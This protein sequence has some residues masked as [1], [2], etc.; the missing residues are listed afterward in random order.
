[1]SDM[2][3]EIDFS[4][5]HPIKDS[6]AMVL[7]KIEKSYGKD[8]ENPERYVQTGIDGL[9]LP[10]GGLVV[11]AAR[12]CYG[13]MACALSLARKLAVEDKKPVGI[14]ACGYNDSASVCTNLL[15]MESDVPLVR[16]RSGLLTVSDF[17]K[18]QAAAGRLYESPIFI[19]DSPNISFAEFEFAARLMIEE[20][21]V[22]AIFVDS[23]EYLQE[24]A[25]ASKDEREYVVSETLKE[26]KK[27]ACELNVPVVV[28][29]ELPASEEDNEPE[30]SD[31]KSNMS[32]PRTAD[33]V[34]LLHRQR[35]KDES[36]TLNA[37]LVTAKNA[38]G[39]CASIPL[40][41]RVCSGSFKIICYDVD[42]GKDNRKNKGTF[43]K[44]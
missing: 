15:A 14:I 11:L 24:I 18:L 44:E 1:M 23:F 20:K 27:A 35:S 30:L 42:R 10:K 16:I 26:Y 22:E 33:V 19:D 38:H 37:R 32:I 25:N 43:K 41:Y 28:L 21:K 40:E 17:E 29:V 3:E 13:K 36:N 8:C 4:I 9:I 12:P 7:D 39:P 6:I 2:N 34:Y 31:F 5:Y